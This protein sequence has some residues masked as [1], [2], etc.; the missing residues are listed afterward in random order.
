MRDHPL[1]EYWRGAAIALALASAF[2]AP[3]AYAAEV[4]LPELTITAPP[5][6]AVT[7]NNPSPTAQVT[8]AQIRDINVINV[9]D[10]LKYTP[11]LFIR[12][13]YIGDTNGIVATRTTGS[14]QSALSLVYADGLLLS[15]LLGNS[16][17]FPPRW[18]LV[19]AEEIE[20]VD[21]LH[22]PFSAL[23]PGNSAGATVLMTTKTPERFEAH[24]RAQGFIQP[25]YKQ[26]GTDDSYSGHHEQAQLGARR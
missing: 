8:Q 11:S 19:G 7:T 9:E 14:Q 22:G 13:R 26:Y 10:S 18:N 4:T 23:L 3:C 21:V 15:N 20:T 17:G 12:K 5:P 6:P 16:F 24:V 1:Q 2:L 25:S